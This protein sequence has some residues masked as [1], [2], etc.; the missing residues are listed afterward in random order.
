MSNYF[1]PFSFDKQAAAANLPVPYVTDSRHLVFA[2][3]A[4]AATNVTIKV[5]GSSQQD[6]P[7]FDSAASA[8]NDWGYIGFRDLADA[9][10]KSGATGI[11]IP[12]TTHHKLY[13]VESNVLQHIAFE[14]TS[15]SGDGVT[16]KGVIKS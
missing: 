8:T 6:A 11:T 3:H 1:T 9:S 5:M 2:V 7:D 12:N 16:I 4:D 14:L 15:V 10:L 13:E